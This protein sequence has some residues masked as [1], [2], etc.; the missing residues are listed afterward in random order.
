MKVNP[1][2]ASEIFLIT[3]H[4]EIEIFFVI[5]GMEMMQ[6]ILLQSFTHW[7]RCSWFNC[8]LFSFSTMQWIPLHNHL[9]RL[10]NRGAIKM[11]ELP[12]SFAKTIGKLPKLSETFGNSRKTFKNIKIFQKLARKRLKNLRFFSKKRKL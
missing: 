9:L 1:N 10:E 2:T 11:P 4:F 8:I 7:K 3:P 6:L 12:V 5:K